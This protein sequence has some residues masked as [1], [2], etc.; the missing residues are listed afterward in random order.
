[1]AVNSGSV[2]VPIE[3]FPVLSMDSSLIV[4]CESH[5][6][7]TV[8][9]AVNVLQEDKM[10]D[11]SPCQKVTDSIE[12]GSEYVVDEYL[13]AKA[14]ADSQGYLTAF[15]TECFDNP[16]ETVGRAFSKIRSAG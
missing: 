14:G 11:R 10:D 8:R 3:F 2:D 1:V 6:A 4:E 7:E 9:K 15:Q 12:I 16:N 5:P 13:A